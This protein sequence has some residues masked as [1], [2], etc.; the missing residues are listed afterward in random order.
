MRA[1]LA[2]TAR[3]PIE[4]L[5]AFARERGWSNLPSIPGPAWSRHPL[6]SHAFAPM[7][8]ERVIYLDSS[9][10]VE[11]VVREPESS[12]LRRYLRRRRPLVSSALAQAEVHRAVMPLGKVALR[13]AR[14]VLSRVDLLRI[15][16]RVLAIAGTTE[17]ANLRT[18]D[19]IHLAT[20][21]LFE[22]TLARFVCHD[23][24]MSDVAAAR[25]WA[26]AAPD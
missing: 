4:R 8:V 7:S 14:D 5:A 24:R 10:I 22:D 13:R 2:V 12:A 18:L 19:A 11:L 26:V 21:S 1:N 23:A 3:S 6:G 16:S 20:A 25:G 9:A 17:P 15:N